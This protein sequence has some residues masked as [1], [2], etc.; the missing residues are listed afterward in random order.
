MY[1]IVND[2]I[3]FVDWLL[4]EM[5]KQGLSQAALAK[6]AHVSRAAISNLINGARGAGRDLLVSIAR[7]LGLPPETVFRAA[8]LF[9]AS[10]DIDEDYENLKYMFEQMS[11]KEKE[12]F[13]AYGRLKLD[14]KAKQQG[15]TRE[16]KTQP[17]PADI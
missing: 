5:N 15:E 13:L 14:L 12:E 7:G 1:S 17:R 11:Q 8:G 6:K 10:P 2:K 16:P 4:E 9:P 3:A